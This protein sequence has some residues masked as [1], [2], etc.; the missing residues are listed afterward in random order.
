MAQFRSVS[1]CFLAALVSSCA[2]L[3]AELV[4][5]NAVVAP[6]G[7]EMSAIVVNGQTPGPVLSAQKGERFQVNVTDLLVDESMNK[8]TTVHWHG[9]N[10][11]GSVEMDGAAMVTQC[12]ITSGHSFVYDFTPVNQSGSFWYHSHFQLQYCEGMRG[13]L[14]IYDPQDPYLGM[15]DVDD[16][17]TIISLA[18][19]YHMNAYDVGPSDNPASTLINGVGR[20][21]GGPP[22]P[23]SVVHVTPGKRYRIRLMNIACRPNFVFTIDN[24]VFTVIEADSEYTTPLEVDSIQIYAG[25]RYSFIL[26]ADQPIDTYWIHAVPNYDS[27]VAGGLHSAILKYDGAPVVDP[28]HRNWTRNN[29]LLEQNL[30]ALVDP[31][32]PGV[33][34]PGGADMSINIE[35]VWD[36][37]MRFLINGYTYTSPPTPV[38]LQI[39]NGNL[40][41]S[42]LKPY[43]SVYTLPANKTI[44]LSIPAGQPEGP[45]PFHLHG[46][47]FSVVRSAGSD[48]YNYVNPVR[49]DTT[50][51]GASGDNVTIRF[52]TENAGPWFLHCHIDFHLEQGMAVV[53][54]EDTNGTAST[55]DISNS[56]KQ[57]CSTYDDASPVTERAVEQHRQRHMKHKIRR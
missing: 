46:H 16:E 9:I 57:L 21:P 27:T 49:R 2:A 41:A 28:V 55:L 25:Q 4:I 47:P 50:S 32:A 10:H 12:P 48:V 37:H 8:S 51:N 30:H 33:A 20:Y 14:V 40:D 45:H 39:L 23:L 1:T 13:A 17:S 35:T 3:N 11:H 26:T 44:E 52:R 56:W 5:S 34:E 29:P 24:H 19:W 54:A 36:G 31:A 53:F 15:Y 18:D 42:Q 7:Y 38:L 22:V 43:G 6:D